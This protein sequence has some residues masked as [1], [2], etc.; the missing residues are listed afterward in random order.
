L[1]PTGGSKSAGKN[2]VNRQGGRVISQTAAYP[3]RGCHHRLDAQAC[4]ALMEVGSKPPAA[5]RSLLLEE[6][7]SA[8]AALAVPHGPARWRHWS[9][10]GVGDMCEFRQWDTAS[11]EVVNRH[12]PVR[13]GY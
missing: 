7:T 5:A 10:E 12:R 3:Q 2:L 4:A 11:G 8:P 13:T 1:G 9:G 6:W